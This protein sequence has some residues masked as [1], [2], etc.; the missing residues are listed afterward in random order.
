MV[1]LHASCQII[2]CQLIAKLCTI[3]VPYRRFPPLLYVF[4][5][6]KDGS[7]EGKESSVATALPNMHDGY[8]RAGCFFVV[9]PHDINCRWNMRR[10]VPLA[11]CVL[12]VC[13]WCQVLYRG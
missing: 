8:R 2:D 10:L 5:M 4:I 13:A 7:S 6:K 3:P 9:V 11:G 1:L 12:R